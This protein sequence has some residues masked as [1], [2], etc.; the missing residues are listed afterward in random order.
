MKD[1]N[2]DHLSLRVEACY[3]LAD[4]LTDAVAREQFLNLNGVEHI[5]ECLKHRN[6]ML[7][8]AAATA[9]VAISCDSKLSAAFLRAGALD[10][11]LQDKEKR[12]RYECPVWETAIEALLR[13]HL[14]IK[15][16]YMSRLDIQDV[17]ED[18]FYVTRHVE[19]PF[20]L[21]EE[22]LEMEVCPIRPIYVANFNA[23]TEKMT[24]KPSSMVEILNSPPKS[25]RSSRISVGI[26]NFYFLI[27]V[28]SNS[29]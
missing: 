8:Q 2:R 26:N 14:P 22:L 17:T 23:R 3:A 5:M 4:S 18:G 1:K 11:M 24:S 13:S 9:L 25:P 20:Q 29:T 15:F 6:L 10:W 28:A 16:A 27:I 21:L 19:R 7:N 12:T